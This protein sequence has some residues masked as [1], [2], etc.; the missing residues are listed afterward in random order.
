MLHRSITEACICIKCEPITIQPIILLVQVH[1]H[2]INSDHFAL[3]HNVIEH[4]SGFLSVSE[5]CE[6]QHLCPFEVD[7]IW[8]CLRDGVLFVVQGTAIFAVKAVT[9]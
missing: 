6:C 7:Q 9:L 3:F 1:T 4:D 5:I 8:Q 2:A